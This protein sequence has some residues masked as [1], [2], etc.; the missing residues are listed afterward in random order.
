MAEMSSR[1]AAA[2]P[3]WTMSES[4]KLAKMQEMMSKDPDSIKK[5]K[6]SARRA[7]F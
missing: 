7:K 6:S 2:N 1:A 4:D 3:A 5:V